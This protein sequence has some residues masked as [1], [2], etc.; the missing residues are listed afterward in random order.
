MRLTIRFA[1]LLV[2][3]GCEKSAP[4]RTGSAPAENTSPQ[5]AMR[6]IHGRFVW[7]G[8]LPAPAELP[9]GFREGK[10]LPL[11]NNAYYP[12][13]SSQSGVPDIVIHADQ[14]PR[15]SA[16][17]QTLVWD[18]ERLSF[19]GT[20]GFKPVVSSAIVGT[21]THIENRT[22]ETF[23][24]RARG[25]AF[26]TLALPVDIPS[27]SRVLQSPGL[28][29]WSSAGNH[30]YAAARTYVFEHASHAV[31]NAEGEFTL[32]VPLST[33]E[34]TYEISDERMAD[35]ERDPETMRIARFRYRPALRVR[36]P[37]TP[38]DDPLTIAIQTRKH[39]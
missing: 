30:Y 38:G 26:F 16:G 13:V 7:R 3:A 37:L 23:L 27:R 10:T 36:I 24:C 20:A 2:I 21:T 17:K 22:K 14:G 34:L 11:P 39:E 18:G 35:Y 31:T 8:P 28:V 5:E 12:R 19:D 33:R 15:S 4:P 6:T 9:V 29:E 25:A 32:Q 1:L